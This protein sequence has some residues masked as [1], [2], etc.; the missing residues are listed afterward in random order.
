MNFLF[1]PHFRLLLLLMSIAIQSPAQN[2]HAREDLFQVSFT[3]CHCLTGYSYTYNFVHDSLVV[4]SDCDSKG[5]VE[6]V[7][8]RQKV[9]E[10]VVDEFVKYV[11]QIRIDTLKSRYVTRGLDGLSRVVIIKRRGEDAKCILLERFDH[12]VIDE[13]VGEMK[14]LIADPKI[15]A[16]R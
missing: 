9:D 3:D 8:Y 5:C 7:I 14:K 6:K 1:K 4:T 16:L 11:S 15:R 2:S 12:P 10:V 13:L